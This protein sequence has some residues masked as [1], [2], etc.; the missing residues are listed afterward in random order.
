LRLEQETLE[1]LHKLGLH[2][3]NQFIRLPRAAMRKRF[4]PPF[5]QQLDKAIGQEME[6]LE[7]IQ[8]VEPYQERLPCLEPIV[9]A[10]GIEMALKQL[11]E[12]LCLRLQ[13]EQKGPKTVA[14][15]ALDAY[16]GYTKKALFGVPI[17]AMMNLMKEDK[18]NIT[19]LIKK[20]IG[21][22]ISF[23][24][25]ES[26][27]KQIYAKMRTVTN[28]TDLTEVLDKKSYLNASNLI[29]SFMS[30]TG[31]KE[32]DNS[33]YNIAYLCERLLVT[34]SKKDSPTKYNYYQMFFDEVLTKR[35]IAYAVS[36]MQGKTLKYNFYSRQFSN[37]L[38]F[39]QKT[40]TGILNWFLLLIYRK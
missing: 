34:S 2:Q 21:S 29:Q 7:P 20:E 26:I 38:I 1:R 36:S 28:K 32:V 15:S 8:P 40:R 11:L 24:D 14:E 18:V 3:I 30:K 31:G 35:K 39:L 6:I 10:V 16:T 19:P 13:Q 23:N 27:L 37:P 17:I 12:K 5:L 33:V 4:G 9:T 25:F 22:Y